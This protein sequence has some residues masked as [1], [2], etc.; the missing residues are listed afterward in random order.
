[1]NDG[2]LPGGTVVNDSLAWVSRRLGLVA[3]VLLVLSGVFYAGLVLSTPGKG[4]HEVFSHLWFLHDVGAE[5]NIPSWF[6]SILWAA[7]AVACFGAAALAPR[8]ASWAL[9]G[10]VG[11]AASIDEHSELHE[12]L[13]QLGGPLTEAWGL[14]LWFTWVIPGLGLAALVALVLWPLV[15]S[16]PRASRALVL[17]GGALFLL[18]AVVVETASGLVL[19]HFGGQVT[20]HFIAVTL[21]EEALEMFGLLLAIAGVLRLFR[22]ERSADGGRS[23]R[24]VG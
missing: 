4:V 17:G 10:I 2:L 13:D 3:A 24:W 20:W 12:R 18:G 9:A 22:V 19:A 11:V 6:A 23:I 7:F 14:G 8:R 1:M 21:V 5:R 15:W 16:L